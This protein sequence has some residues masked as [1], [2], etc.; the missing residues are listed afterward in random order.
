[1]LFR[2]LVEPSVPWDP[3]GNQNGAMHG[4][5]GRHAADTEAQSAFSGGE[6][7][8]VEELIPVRQAISGKH[9]A[10]M[11]LVAIVA[12]QAQAQQTELL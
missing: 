8:E 6:L 3:E 10:M 7:L 11:A 5:D 1:M 12:A 2:S 9:F 4:V